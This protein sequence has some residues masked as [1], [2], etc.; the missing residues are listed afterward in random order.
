MLWQ[1]GHPEVI[2]SDSYIPFMRALHLRID[3]EFDRFLRPEYLTRAAAKIRVEKIALGGVVKDGIPSLDNPEMIAGVQAPYLRTDDLV[4]GISINGDV[5]A[6]PLRIMGWHEMFNDLIGGVPVALAYCTLCGSGILFETRDKGR[7]TPLIYG[8]S[9]FLY[10]SK[11]L[12]V[13]RAA[14]SLLNHFTG[15]PVSGKLADCGIQLVQ[16]PVVIARWDDWLAANPKMQVLAL[17]T[18]Y[19]RDYGSGVVCQDYFASDALKFLALADEGQQRQKDYV[20]GIRRFAGRAGLAADRLCQKALINDAVADFPVVLIGDPDGRT[21]R[22]YERDS[23]KFSGNPGVLVSDDGAA[24][25]MGE[26]ALTSADGRSLASVPGQVSY[27]FAWDGCEGNV[28]TLYGSNHAPPA[29]LQIR[30]YCGRGMAYG[31]ASQ[32]ARA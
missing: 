22:A 24:W 7:R 2:P 23:L 11:K 12:I 5:R 14:Q 9:G 8:S 10:R 13:D 15:Q 3:P 18:G 21:V 25:A 29:T 30:V 19:R 1:E 4:F 20:F 17:E 32:G 16:R 27:W 31:S 6:Y 26:E 28:A